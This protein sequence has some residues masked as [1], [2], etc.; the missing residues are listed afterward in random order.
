[1]PRPLKVDRPKRLEIQ[2]PESI[3]TK[4]QDELYSELEDRIPHGAQSKLITNLLVGWLRTR[5]VLV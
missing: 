5:G 4:V 3:H 1:M 2:I